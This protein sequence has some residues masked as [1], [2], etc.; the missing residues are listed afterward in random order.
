M[1]RWLAAF[2]LT[3]LVEVPIYAKALRGRAHIAFAASAI[4]HPAV[5]FGFPHLGRALDLSYPMTVACAEVFAVGVEWLWLRHFGVKH[6]WAWSLGANAASV[7]VGL[8]L[9]AWIGWP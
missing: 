7:I 5:W 1:K 4:T 9:R 6:A 2:L 3:Q 8:S